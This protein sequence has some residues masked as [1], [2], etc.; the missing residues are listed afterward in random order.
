M[1]Q[2]NGYVRVQPASTTSL[3]GLG[4]Y[5]D[6]STCTPLEAQ[7]DQGIQAIIARRYL[8][9]TILRT[10]QLRR[11]VIDVISTHSVTVNAQS[12]A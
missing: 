3:Y 4:E 7:A 2:G 12:P 9:E 5:T 11:L 10:S 8:E 1:M 6:P